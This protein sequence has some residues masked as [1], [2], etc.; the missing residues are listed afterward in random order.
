MSATVETEVTLWSG[1]NTAKRRPFKAQ[2]PCPC[3][4]DNRGREVP[5]VGYVTGSNAKGEGITLYAPDEE[6]YQHLVRVFGEA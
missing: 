2:R 6:T 1:P 5:L 3:G 4:C